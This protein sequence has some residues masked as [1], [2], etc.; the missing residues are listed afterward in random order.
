MTNSRNH[1]AAVPSPTRRCSQALCLALATAVALAGCGGTNPK[2][3]AVR[4]MDDRDVV[5]TKVYPALEGTIGQFAFF[6]D[7]MPMPVEGW[8]LVGGL[9][10]T[11]S[12]EMSPEVR[13]YLSEQLYRS[14]AGSYAK[15]TEQY[16][17]ERILASS[18]ISAVEVHG[19]IPPMARRGDPFDL[20]VKA[21]PDTQTTSIEGGLLWTA[22]LKIIG[23]RTDIDTRPVALARG[24][25]YIPSV[26]DG[27]TTQPSSKAL[28]S[29]RV[30]GGGIVSESREIRLQLRSPSMR[31]AGAIQRAI[32]SRFPQRDKCADAVSDTIVNLN[33]PPQYQGCPAQFVELVLHMYLAQDVPGFTDTQAQKLVKALEDPKAPHRELGLALE[34]LGRSILP[35]YLEPLYTSSNPTVR[36]WAGRAG[37]SM[38]DVGGL[39]V[40]E[41]TIKDVNSP[42]RYDAVQA[43]IDVSHDGD[44]MRSTLALA[45]MLDSPNPRDRIVGYGALVSI[46]SHAIHTYSVAKKMLLDIVPSDG[47]PLIYATQSDT[48]RIALIGHGFTLP[49]GALFISSDNRLTVSALDESAAGASSTTQPADANVVT[50]SALGAP[51]AAAVNL[52]KETPADGKDA[53]TLF[54]RSPLGDHPVSLKTSASLPDVIARVAWSP[55][56]LAADFDP[57]AVYI[58]ASYQRVVEMLSAMCADKSINADFMLEEAPKIP[59]GNADALAGRPE[60]STEPLLPKTP[61]PLNG[62]T[63]APALVPH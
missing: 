31:F 24:P 52:P 27:A 12:G 29:G 14:N 61:Q 10:G 56:P 4:T 15:G 46:R 53:V 13:Q 50:A 30:L 39:V 11:G 34:G 1:P 25:V 49:P 3:K 9:P 23:L 2:S 44:T 42:L 62:P 21:L 54:W 43:I 8:A 19:V 5:I 26:A 47:P 60:G 18:Q 16:N 48:P 40:L 20:Y 22:P 17:P 45:Q 57:H 51:E 28:R 33:V 63:T 58:G 36:F 59:T 35:E 32:N 7:S 55:D 6:A 37:A 38:K 41:E